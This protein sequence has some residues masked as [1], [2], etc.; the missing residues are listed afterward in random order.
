MAVSS[1]CCASTVSPSRPLFIIEY[2]VVRRYNTARS[3][4]CTYGKQSKRS[5]RNIEA[6]PLCLD[7]NRVPTRW[8]WNISTNAAAELPRLAPAR[9]QQATRGPLI[10]QI[11]AND[12]QQI[13]EMAERS[14][15]LG[16]GRPECAFVRMVS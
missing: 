6:H 3:V 4:S 2:T 8:V 11:P 9:Q 5:S 16:S 14:K 1:V 10:T 12:F 7:G 13:G 15:A